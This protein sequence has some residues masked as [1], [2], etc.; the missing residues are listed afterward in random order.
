M[1]DGPIGSSVVDETRVFDGFTI[2]AGAFG[3]RSKEIDR[4]PKESWQER[5]L[6]GSHCK[7]HRAIEFR[8]T[9]GD[10]SLTAAHA[11]R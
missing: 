7:S 10:V 1:V 4:D 2:V 6:C 8:K 3:R 11:V 5:I 9:H